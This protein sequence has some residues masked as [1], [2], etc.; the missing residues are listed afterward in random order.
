VTAEAAHHSAVEAPLREAVGAAPAD[1]GAWMP[2]AQQARAT[3]A[4]RL[5]RAEAAADVAR[6]ALVVARAEAEA[7]EQLRAARRAAHRRARLAREQAAL[8]EATRR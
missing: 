3:T 5:G 7:L 4:T 8:E 2:A 6:E 1:Y